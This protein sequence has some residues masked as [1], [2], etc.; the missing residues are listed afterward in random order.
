MCAMNERIVLEETR[1]ASMVSSTPDV[2]LIKLTYTFRVLSLALSTTWSPV[3]A[4]AEL[5][6]RLPHVGGDYS[7]A[8]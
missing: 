3:R 1:G 6:Y 5:S 2:P 8:L 4:Y 7:S